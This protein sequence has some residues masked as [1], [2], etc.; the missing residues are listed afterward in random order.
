VIGSDR[1]AQI[2]SLSIEKLDSKKGGLG[3]IQ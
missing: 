3:V 1:L 2:T